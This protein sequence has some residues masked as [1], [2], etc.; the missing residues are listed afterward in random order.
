MI[1]RC[2]SEDPE[3]RPSFSQVKSTLKKMIGKECASSLIASCS[4][5]VSFSCSISILDN[6][7]GMMEKYAYNLE[8]IVE[9]RTQELVEEKKKT[10]RLLYKMLP[11]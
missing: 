9:E 2:W 4:Q 7:L 10:D 3:E 11:S 6:I 1:K 8:E 5:S